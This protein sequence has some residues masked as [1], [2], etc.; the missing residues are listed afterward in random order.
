MEAKFNWNK[1]YAIFE[2]YPIWFF[3]V[4]MKPEHSLTLHSY[5]IYDFAAGILMKHSTN[6]W[7]W[8]KTNFYF[9]FVEL[10]FAK[11]APKC[12]QATAAITKSRPASNNFNQNQNYAQTG[13]IELNHLLQ[14]KNPI[15]AAP[16]E[17]RP[18]QCKCIKMDGKD[19][20]PESMAPDPL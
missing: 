7:N 2:I 14:N 11:N 3:S 4:K 6:I 18:E 13:K 8:I 1:A 19:Q 15:K 10:L 17:D 9:I 5:L 20:P 16:V 12:C